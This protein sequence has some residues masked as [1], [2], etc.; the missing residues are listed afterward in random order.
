MLKVFPQLADTHLDHVWGGYVDISMNRA[1]DFGRLAQNVLYL[2]GFSGHGI[3]MAGMAGQLAAE[4]VA[5]QAERFDL[6]A[7]IPHHVFPGGRMFRTPALVLGM[8]W[9]RLRDYL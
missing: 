2:Q 9:Y 1:P 5:G 3:A 4:V 6:F 8:L 7:R